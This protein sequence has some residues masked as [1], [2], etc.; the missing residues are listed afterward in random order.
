MEEIEGFEGSKGGTP[1]SG[2]TF[3]ASR[4]VERILANFFCFYH[5]RAESRKGTFRGDTSW[6]G[7]FRRRRDKEGHENDFFVLLFS[8]ALFSFAFFF[9]EW[10][11]WLTFLHVYAAHGIDETNME[12]MLRNPLFFAL[13]FFFFGFWNLAKI[14][15][16]CYSSLHILALSYECVTE[17]TACVATC[18]PARLSAYLPICLPSLG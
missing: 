11:I 8:L 6:E 7:L 10:M 14:P 9:L 18:P 1:W 2:Y 16:A 13:D 17:V 12:L 5:S 4:I 3:K 15:T